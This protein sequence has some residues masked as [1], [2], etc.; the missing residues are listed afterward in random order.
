[1]LNGWSQDYE[2]YLFALAEA[3]KLS[4]VKKI[5]SLKYF[6]QLKSLYIYQTNQSNHSNQSNQS[7]KT[8]VYTSASPYS[9]AV[10]N[11]SLI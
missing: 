9:F 6:Y 8:A 4:C 7:I 5:T 10:S 3:L 2:N 11:R 1:M